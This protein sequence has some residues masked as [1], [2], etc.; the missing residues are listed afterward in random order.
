MGNTDNFNLDDSTLLSPNDS[1]ISLDSSTFLDFE[2]S[3]ELSS[4]QLFNIDDGELLDSSK[5]LANNT[6]ILEAEPLVLS[7]QSNSTNAGFNKDVSLFAQLKY[8]TGAFGEDGITNKP[9]IKDQVEDID[10]AI[11]L[12]K[13]EGE[14]RKD[15]G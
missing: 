5:S 9:I 12:K 4:R 2:E 11:A 7:K 13:E 14:R 3:D 8:D 6:T 15:R 1:V 10:A